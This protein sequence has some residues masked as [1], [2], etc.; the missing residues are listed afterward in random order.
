M[1]GMSRKILRDLGNNGAKKI[2]EITGG[3]EFRKSI[4]NIIADRC[5]FRVIN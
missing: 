5:S 2:K 4:A 3:M 1:S